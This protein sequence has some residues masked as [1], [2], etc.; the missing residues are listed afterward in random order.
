MGHGSWK[1]AFALGVLWNLWT[2]YEYRSEV[3]RI[4]HF[5]SDHGI[6]LIAMIDEGLNI[7]SKGGH[8]LVHVIWKNHLVE[9]IH[10]INLLLTTFF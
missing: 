9:E 1:R 2:L 4:I 7:W 3:L 8:P 6:T 5:M 10:D